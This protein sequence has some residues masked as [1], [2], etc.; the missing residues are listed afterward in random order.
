MAELVIRVSGQDA[1]LIS[2]VYGAGGAPVA[3]QR[4]D[5]LVVDAHVAATHPEIAATARRAGVP[6]LVDPLTH[7]LQDV[8][9][10]ADPWAKLSFANERAHTPADL[11]AAPRQ[12]RLVEE[13]LSFQIDHGA[14]TLIA[15]YAHI[16]RADDGWVDIQRRL[17]AQTRRFLDRNNVRIPVMAV[18][19]LG[20]RLLDRVTWPSVLNPLLEASALLGPVPVAL[21]A[22]KVDQGVHPER[23]LADLL[24]TIGQISSRHP[25]IAW[26]QGA[27]GEACVVGG[28]IGYEV[29]IGWRERCDLRSASAAHRLPPSGGGGARPVYVASV[30]RSIPKPSLRVLMRDRVLLPHLACTHLPCCPTGH[31]ALLGDARAHTIAAR[32]RT[33]AELDAADT[34]AWKWQLLTQISERG[35]QVA[36]RINIA[37]RLHDAVSRIDTAALVATYAVAAAKRRN[38]TE[39]AA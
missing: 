6:F 30:R 34:L 33:L 29:G 11:A 7:Y 4:P 15:P 25:V 18:F 17:L 37:S 32:A 26:N 13:C 27:L 1:A 38:A 23:R 9:H 22:A 20:W 35:L 31:S 14:T 8:Q 39:R 36:D 24:A 16:E 19:G 10:P 21:A 12:E 3:R 2:R 5:R 28:A